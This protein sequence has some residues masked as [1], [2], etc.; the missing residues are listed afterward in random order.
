MDNKLIAHSIAVA[1]LSLEIGKRCGAD[2][3]L[4]ECGALFHDIGRIKENGISHGIIGS[5]MVLELGYPIEL[6][7]IIKRH[8]GGGIDP[9]EAKNLGLKE[10]DLLPETLEEKIVCH[11][12]NLI[13]KDK[14]ITLE[15]ILE[16]YRKMNLHKQV[17]RIRSLHR[18]LSDLIGTD[19]DNLG[20]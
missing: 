15:Q 10:T 2:L 3:P 14:K 13:K 9:E 5:E 18:Y 11:T 12:D 1:N 6:A 20:V 17:E 19:I 4:L 16:D 8:V 7:N